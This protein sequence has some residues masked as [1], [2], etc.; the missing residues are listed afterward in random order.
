MVHPY[1]FHHSNSMNL[2]K[3]NRIAAGILSLMI[4]FSVLFSSFYIS[5]E[6]LHSCTGDGCPVCACIHQCENTLRRF[7]GRAALQA[8][9]VIPAVSLYPAGALFM[10]AVLH[11]TPVSAKVRIND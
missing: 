2:W 1:T 4:L 3:T 8:P 5:A 11:K 9:V 6:S 10:T 7:C